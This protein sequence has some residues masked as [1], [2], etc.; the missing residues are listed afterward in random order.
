M[1]EL[2]LLKHKE[3]FDFMGVSKTWFDSSRLACDC[4]G[5]GGGVCMYIKSD[6]IVNM[7]DDITNRAREEVE[8]L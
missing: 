2:E 5:V 8:S 4:P 6:L 3:D 1:T 7:K